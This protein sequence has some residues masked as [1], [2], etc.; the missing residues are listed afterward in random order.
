[1]VTLMEQGAGKVEPAPPLP[2]VSRPLWYVSLSLGWG[3]GGGP[4][5]VFARRGDGYA[6]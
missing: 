2:T 1:M 4:A 3:E 5:P 6:R